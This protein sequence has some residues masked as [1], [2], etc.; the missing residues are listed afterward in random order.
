MKR[1]LLIAMMAFSLLT[2][3]PMDINATDVVNP[4]VGATVLFD[5]EL[6]GYLDISETDIVLDVG[7]SQVLT[8]DNF[9]LP[10]SYFNYIWVSEK[11]AVAT[12]D[13]TG[14]IT[15]KGLGTTTI[16]VFYGGLTAECKVTVKLA[17]TTGA[18]VARSSDTAL[19]VSWTKVAGA[20]G[21]VVYRSTSETGTYKSVKTI[22]K[23]STVSF[24]NTKLKNATTYYYKVRAYNTVSGKKVYG[25][26]SSV[27]VGAALKT[28]AVTVAR[29]EFDTIKVSWK[30]VAG[31]S[32]YEIVR[33]ES[34][35]GTYIFMDTVAGNGT[36]SFDDDTVV[37]NKTYYYKVRAFKEIGAV[38]FYGAYSAVKSTKATLAT[39]T[40]NVELGF[41]NVIAI[42]WPAVNGAELYEVYRSTSEKGTYISLGTTSGTGYDD[43]VAGNGQAYYY[44]VRAGKHVDYV[45]VF[46]SFSKV[47]GYALFNKP[48]INTVTRASDTSLKITWPKVAGAS[49][50]EIARSTSKT[51][52]YK[53]VKT[54][55]KGSTVSYTDK[56]TNGTLYYYKLRVYKTIMGKKVFGAFESDIVEAIAFKTPTITV[57]STSISSLEI[58]FKNI[59]GDVTKYEVYKSDSEKGTYTSF[60][61]VEVSDLRCT[62]WSVIFNKNY[63]YKV[64]A[65]KITTDTTLHGPF[66]AVK[67]AKTALDKPVLETVESTDSGI[68]LY[69][70]SG[71]SGANVYQIHRATSS[72]GKYSLLETLAHS[73]N[74]FLDTKVKESTVY[75]YKVRAGI[76]VDGKPVY[77][78]Y[79]SI[80]K[81]AWVK[82]VVSMAE[83]TDQ[84][85]SSSAM[86]S[87]LVNKNGNGYEIERK[88]S[89]EPDTSY[90]KIATINNRLTASYVDKTVVSGNTYMY[91]VRV[92]KTINKVKYYSRYYTI[93][94]TIP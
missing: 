8:I 59:P 5:G 69:L 48:S 51:G 24:T 15:A 60:T 90:K 93:S 40:I 19:K 41:G 55:T 74:Y 80:K 62:D 28:P 85:T 4:K 31:A 45:P 38:D 78:P 88:L 81:I 89:S 84:L 33:S 75:Y 26:Y 64:R 2:V 65:I 22:T 7:A 77:G 76:L 9:T 16:R 21:Y 30:K 18:K 83:N 71:V 73:M 14:K 91:R 20:T 27:V 92:F 68:Y 17:A 6:P 32:G 11:P 66:S 86:F 52:T 53:V 54:I 94:I 13:S 34:K 42:N 44:K 70:G 36:V 56:V 72:N 47:K 3:M 58:S 67:S 37:V 63:Y 61:T 35:N 50:Y 12:V 43:Y 79:S 87:W 23:G 1:I 57:K 25:E 82:P 10:S 46:G 39:P 49:G 29:K